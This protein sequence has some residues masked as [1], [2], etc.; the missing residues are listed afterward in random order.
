MRPLRLSRD[1]GFTLIELLVTMSVMGIL[2]ALAMT[3]FS[4]WATASEHR[5]ARDET[6]SVLRNAAERALSEGR[7][8]CVE[9]SAGGYETYRFACPPDAGV[10]VAGPTKLDADG[11]ALAPAVPAAP[12]LEDS[13]PVAGTCAYFYP[14]G[15]AS[16]GAVY[17]NRQGRTPFTVTIVGLTSRVFAS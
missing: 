8:Y 3:S 16:A 15:N 2:G 5:S 14:R 13:C 17:V 7:T 12:N 10:L 1:E 11:V 4:S 6:L 9:I